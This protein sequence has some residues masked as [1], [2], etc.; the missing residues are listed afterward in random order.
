MAKHV[1]TVLG[2]ISPGELGVT[3]PH[4]HLITFP[5]QK[6]RYDPDYKLPSAEKALSEVKLFKAAGGSTI[7]E[8]TTS[9]YG[10]DVNNLRKI[11]DETGV[12]IIATTGAIMESLFPAEIY[13]LTDSELTNLFIRDVNVGME[14]TDIKAG[15]LKFGA[16]NDK[17][18]AAEKKAARAACKAHLETGAP[19]TTHTINGTMAMSI[20]EFLQTE[21]VKLENAVIGHLD[22]GSLQLGYILMIARTGVYVQFD[23][24]GKTKYYTDD[25]RVEVIKQLIEEGFGNRILVSGDMGRQSY[26]KSYGGAPGFEH[27]LNSFIPLMREMEIS[28]ENIKLLTVDNPKNFFAF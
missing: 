7:A 24:I 28:E 6:V 11:S 13:D 3:L 17:F 14:N 21:G 25:L 27:L 9:G 23:S 10:R 18:S 19:I 26:L 12:H 20:V 1:R 2:D 16:S 22:K 5:P 8:M 4:E 15:V